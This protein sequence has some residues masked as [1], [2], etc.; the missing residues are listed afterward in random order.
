MSTTARRHGPQ[1][2]AKEQEPEAGRGADGYAL[3]QAG[4]AEED[5]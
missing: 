4:A 5:L 1:E 2:M 3:H